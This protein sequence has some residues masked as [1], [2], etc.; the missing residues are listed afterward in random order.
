[1]Y[2]SRRTRIACSMVFESLYSR[3]IVAESFSQNLGD[4][5]LIRRLGRLISDFCRL[6]NESL[7][8]RLTFES[9]LK[10]LGVFATSV[11]MVA[12]D[13]CLLSSGKTGGSEEGPSPRSWLCYSF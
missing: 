13:E 11:K 1:M 10:N 12:G 8:R 2:N 9:R 3:C 5:R 7:A 4:S 6:Y